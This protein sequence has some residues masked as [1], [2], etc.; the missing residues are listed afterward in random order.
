M[1]RFLSVAD[2]A[3]AY[4]TREAAAKLAAQRRGSNARDF[5]AGRIFGVGVRLGLR[6]ILHLQRLSIVAQMG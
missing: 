5:A 6:R 4:R 2:N 1:R 3:L